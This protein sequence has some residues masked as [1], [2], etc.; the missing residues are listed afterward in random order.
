MRATVLRKPVR[1]RQQT[2]CSRRKRFHLRDNFAA[3]RKSLLSG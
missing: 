1:Q 2:C 3:L